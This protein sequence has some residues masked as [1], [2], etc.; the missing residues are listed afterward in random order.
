MEWMSK[1]E[2]CDY[3]STP[4]GLREITKDEWCEIMFSYITEQEHRQVRD[5]NIFDLQMFN[6]HNSKHEL[7]GVGIMDDWYDPDT[8]KSRKERIYRFCIYGSEQSW[9]E[10]RKY[11][12][13]QFV[14]DN[15]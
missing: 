13:S 11:F 4:R 3:N 7:L 14:R 10:Y 2:R 6:V 1:E 8:C 9:R 15:S 5:G 12:A